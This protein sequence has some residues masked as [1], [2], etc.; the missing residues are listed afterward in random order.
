MKFKTLLILPLFVNFLLAVDSDNDGVSDEIELSMGTDPNNGQEYDG[1]VNESGQFSYAFNLNDNWAKYL[2]GSNQA[3]VYSESAVTKYWKPTERGQEGYYVYQIPVDGPI[4]SAKLKAHIYAWTQGSDFNFDQDAYAHLEVSSDGVTWHQVDHQSAG[5]MAQNDVFDISEYV[6][7]ASNVF[8]RS[9]LLSNYSPSI[10]AR[11][12]R[13]S[14]SSASFMLVIN[15]NEPNINEPLAPILDLETFYESNSGENITIDATPSDSYP[16]TYTYQWSFK[17][18]GYNSYFV[19]PSNHVSTAA[20]YPMFGDS[21]NNGTWKVEVTN[22]S[23]TTS[24]EFEY[25][26]FNDADSDGLSDGQEEFVLGTDP[27]KRDSDDD[28]L[29]DNIETN[30]GV[31]VSSSDT[32]TDPNNADSDG[33]GITD[34]FEVTIGTDPNNTDNR[35]HTPSEMDA[36]RAESRTA[37]QQDVTGN[38]AQY[39]LHTP[40]EMDDNYLSGRGD[41]QTDVTNNPSQYGLFTSSDLS[42]AQSSSRTAGQQDVI[43]SPSDYDLM[44][45]VGVFDMRVSQLGISMNGDKASM[46]FTIQSSNNL[47]E[48]NNEETIRR[49]YMMPSDKNFMRVSV[50]PQLEPEPLVAI[51]TDTYGD[52]LVYDE[53]NNLYVNDYNTPLFRN[54]YNYKKDFHAQFRFY[55]VESTD[56]GYI[57]LLKKTTQ[58]A[59]ITFD[60]DGVYLNQSIIRDLSDY[61]SVFGQ[62]LN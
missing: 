49:E 1:L 6:N 34:G 26:V 41:G 30:T 35:L 25:R 33:D 38:P 23:G 2:I 62:N 17:A 50:G 3:E 45:S 54:G 32:G 56:D 61:E 5:V 18:V 28:G 20:N 24:A 4:V 29:D 13:T 46:N 7:G 12:L 14:S 9:R 8:V 57:C 19:I 10:F 59:I 52:K 51:A 31:Y 37:G 47:E 39:G 21:D 58:N 43:S 16:T 36:A 27:N 11:S 22:E 42:D 48:W 55:A 53:S 15:I 44:S 60:L 40:S